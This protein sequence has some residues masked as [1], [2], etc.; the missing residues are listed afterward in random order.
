MRLLTATISNL[1]KCNPNVREPTS[2]SNVKFEK[3]IDSIDR[4]DL[5]DIV[6]E[7]YDPHPTIAKISV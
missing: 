2:F 4:F 1:S 3:E 7:G 5:E 6:V